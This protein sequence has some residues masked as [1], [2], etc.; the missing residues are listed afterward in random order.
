MPRSGLRRPART[1]SAL[2]LADRPGFLIRRLHQIHVTLFSEACAAFSITPVQYSVM[3]ALEREGPLDQMS[4]ASEV[5]IDRANATDVVRRLEERRLI[6]RAA[7]P[8]DSRLKICSLT[9]AGRR[10]AARMRPAVEAAHA[11]TIAA[12]PRT[13]RAAFVASLRRLVQANNALGR[14]KLRLR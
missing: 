5:G 4:L 13:E 14:T 12:L 3:T 10:L 9:A 11:R 6:A 7:S 2:H 8:D 1:V